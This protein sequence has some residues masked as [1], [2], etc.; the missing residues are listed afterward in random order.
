MFILLLCIES[1]NTRSPP[2]LY[3]RG[4]GET[5]KKTTQPKKAEFPSTSTKKE[6]VV[7]GRLGGYPFWCARVAADESG[8]Y[9]RQQPRPQ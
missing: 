8:N 1:H 9:K 2:D 4:K 6:R 3:V 7:W 5:A